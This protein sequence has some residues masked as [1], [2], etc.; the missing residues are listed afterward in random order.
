MMKVMT[1]QGCWEEWLARKVLGKT[2]DPC[3][4]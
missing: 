3:E 2:W 1:S 4:H